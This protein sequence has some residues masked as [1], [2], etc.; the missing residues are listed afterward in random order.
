MKE[1]DHGV[2]ALRRLTLKEVQV[3]L[4]ED[5]ALLQQEGIFLQLLHLL[6]QLLSLVL[7]L[8]SF[9]VQIFDVIF[10]ICLR[11]HTYWVWH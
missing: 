2:H 5:K 9:L 10:R 4:Q 1:L 7:C 6:L 11:G 8:P 3:L